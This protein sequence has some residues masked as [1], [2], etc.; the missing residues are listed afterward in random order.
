MNH[1]PIGGEGIHADFISI[2]RFISLHL[3]FNLIAVVSVHTSQ[4]HISIS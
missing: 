2:K 3:S 1:I 4:G